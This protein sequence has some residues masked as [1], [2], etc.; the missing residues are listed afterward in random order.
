MNIEP[1]DVTV[2][3]LADGY[4]DNEDEGVVGYSGRLDVRPPYQREFVYKD[5]Q[6]DAVIDTAF[7]GYPLNIMYWAVREDGNFEII[8]GQQRTIS[9]C[10]YVNGDFSFEGL[11][12]NNLPADKREAFLN[13]RLTVY[14]CSGTD[15][16]KLA[17]FKT[18]NIAGEKLT[19]QELRNA[20]YAGT[21]VSAAKR[22]FSRPNQGAHGL[23]SDYVSGDP[24]RQ[25][26]LEKAIRWISGDA[27]E[28]YM[29]LHQHDPDA[30]TE[31]LYFQS[32]IAWV[33]ALFPVRRKEM[34]DVP[35][36]LLYNDFKDKH[37]NADELEADVSRLMEDEDVT[38]KRGIYS[39]VLN[40]EERHLSIR[41]F[42]DNQ[43]REAYERQ[44]GICPKCKKHF[45]I[46][47]ME[48]DHIT[49][50]SQGG[51]TTAENC[52]MLCKTDHRRKGDL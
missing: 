4:A 37:P 49:P 30:N 13:Y 12:F 18:V 22:I 52:Q 39:Y 48:G 2:R 50:W 6:R 20:V 28:D 11:Y 44:K 42:T 33:K 1:T 8:D 24:K 9:L 23:S 3:E 36:G 25:D 38:N 27:I 21:W 10:Q 19:E 40:G 29:G 32:V 5:K 26:L 14:R 51:R 43:K 35:W 31:W 46:E 16:E 41:A 17:W 34:K 45:E 47:G 7:K 15:S